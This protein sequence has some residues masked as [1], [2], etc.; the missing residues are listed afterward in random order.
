[1]ASFLSPKMCFVYSFLRVSNSK[2]LPF[3]P[4]T[5]TC[6]SPPPAPVASTKQRTNGPV[7]AHL[8]SRPSKFQTVTF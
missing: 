5:L 7:N 2:Q 8:I 1:M 3:S 6:S 4:I